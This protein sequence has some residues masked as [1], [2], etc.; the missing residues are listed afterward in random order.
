VSPT[1]GFTGAAS[2]EDEAGDNLGHSMYESMGEEG[3][4]T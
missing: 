1:G 2:L 4:Q 3:V